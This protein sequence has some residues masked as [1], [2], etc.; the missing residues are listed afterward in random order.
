MKILVTHIRP[1][2]DDICGIWLYRKYVPS[3][4]RAAIRFI[5][6]DLQGGT[7]YGAKPVDT[8]PAVVHIGVCRGRYDEHKGN[9][10]DSAATLVFKDLGRR[11]LLPRDPTT[12]MALERVVAYVLEGDLGR[13]I[14]REGWFYEVSVVL[15]SI[16]AS[17]E[18]ARTGFVLLEALLSFMKD[19]V[20]LDRDWRTKKVFK[21]P[22]G[23]GAGV[24][25]TIGAAARGYEDG[26]VLVAQVDPK[27][28]YRSIR[29]RATSRVN[30]VKIYERL[31][32]LEPKAEWYLHHSKRLLICGDDVAPKVRLSKLSLKQLIELVRV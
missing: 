21:T 5:N 22:W 27:R 29:A 20:I 23:R 4:K 18:R 3:W 26:F 24:V 8:D 17:D 6:L 12:R 31:K 28:D 10:K 32:Q 2:L 13:R 16:P 14:G 15:L 11:K 30:L 7:P 9:L 19:R 25:S 1:H